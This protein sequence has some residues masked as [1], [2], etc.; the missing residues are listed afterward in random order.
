M[1]KSILVFVLCA[2]RCWTVWRKRRRL[3][4]PYCTVDRQIS[5]IEKLVFGFSGSHAGRQVQ[6]LASG[7]EDSG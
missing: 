6:F 5:S 3:R 4:Q 2:G 1:R 7:F